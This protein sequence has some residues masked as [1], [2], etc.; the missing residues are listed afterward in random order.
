MNESISSAST[1]EEEEYLQNKKPEQVSLY[2]SLRDMIKEKIPD[3]FQYLQKPNII[4]QKKQ[5]K[6]NSFALN[7]YIIYL[8]KK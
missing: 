1:L 2:I 5:N 7:R 4:T 6:V 8:N 3:M